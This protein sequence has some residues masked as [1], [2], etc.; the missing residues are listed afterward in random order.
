[1]V[2]YFH[3]FDTRVLLELLNSVQ[4]GMYHISLPICFE[5][6][7]SLLNIIQSI[8]SEIGRGEHEM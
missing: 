7:L 3:E 6:F 5:L 1:M 8:L 2:D 4:G